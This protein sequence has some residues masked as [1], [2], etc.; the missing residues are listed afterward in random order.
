MCDA[1]TTILLDQDFG[2][3]CKEQ[4]ILDIFMVKKVWGRRLVF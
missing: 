4:E 1:M 2:M 3:V